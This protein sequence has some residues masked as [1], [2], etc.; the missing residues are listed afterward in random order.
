[1]SI[2]TQLIEG[3]SQIEKYNQQV[4]SVFI[5][6]ATFEA[7]K[8][9]NINEFLFNKEGSK[10]LGT[11]YG[12]KVYLNETD[13]IEFRSSTRIILIPSEVKLERNKKFKFI[14]EA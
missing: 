8:K 14:M 7:I 9:E 1:M 13:N 4:V 6:S 3:F 10:S 2:R 11:I 12:A 5:S